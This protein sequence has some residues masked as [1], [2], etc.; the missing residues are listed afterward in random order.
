MHFYTRV[1]VRPRIA[2][3]QLKQDLKNG[4]QNYLQNKIIV[5]EYLQMDD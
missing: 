2:F 4:V 1:F 3:W 5:I